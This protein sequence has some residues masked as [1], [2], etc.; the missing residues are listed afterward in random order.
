MMDA[1]ARRFPVFLT[2]MLL[3]LPALPGSLADQDEPQPVFD[4]QVVVT[5]TGIET[6][7]G[8]VGSTITVLTKEEMDRKQRRTV[9]DALRE[10]PG[11]DVRRTGGP[12]A[13]TSV[14]LRGTDSDHTLVLVDGVEF[15][16]SSSPNRAAF[17]DHMTLDNVDRIEV[18]RGPQSTLYGSDAIGGVI[19]IIT[20]RGQGDP[21]HEAWA[22]GGRYSTLRGGFS[23][24]GGG[25]R[26]NY[27]LSGSYTETDSFSARS[28]PGEERD[29]YRNGSVVG[30]VGFDSGQGFELDLFVRHLDAES[31]FDG[32]PGFGTEPGN[33]TDARQSMVKV[34]PRLSLF[35]GRWRQRWSLQTT[36]HERDTVGDSSSL[37]RGQL[38]GVEWRN[39]LTLD[40]RNTLTL[41]VDGAWEKGEFEGFSSFDD[42]ARSLGFFAQDQWKLGS[43]LYG[44]VGV[45]VDDHDSFGSEATYRVAAGYRIGESGTTLRAS[46]GTGFKAPSL[47]EL[48]DS[49][50]GNPGLDPET[51]LG[52]DL[53]VEQRWA[54]R[55]V[56]A[57]ATL[58]HNRVEDQILAEFDPNTFACLGY[59][60]LDEAETRGVETFAHLEPVTNLAI[61]IS[62]TYTDTEARGTPS[63]FLL[64]EGSRLLLRPE[65]KGNL[66]LH[67]RLGEAAGITLDLLYVGKRDDPAGTESDEYWLAN[68]AG[69]WN[70]TEMLQLFARVEN[71]LDEEYEDVLGFNT[72]GASGYLGVRLRF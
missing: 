44:T 42:S 25:E 52:F 12:G 47:S 65:H 3:L 22:E 69:S 48:H 24:A 17:L 64:S 40:E 4:E 13:V 32:F 30:R 71:L 11:V 15:N 49:D 28:A 36:Q 37:A 2:V 31:A 9:A 53:G 62:Y 70:V 29:P 66:G 38:S 67:Q 23:S 27:S 8:E 57:G 61:R 63:G 1:H 50:C 60:N 55:R 10:V 51:S 7:A 68:L 45:R 21:T 72:A 46:L 20:R 54:E 41:G 33:L 5:A 26:F 34:E 59:A 39:D 43:R 19:N 56:S 18:L 14:F 35:D 6:P 58:F 16:D